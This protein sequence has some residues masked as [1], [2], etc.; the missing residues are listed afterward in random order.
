MV[1]RKNFVMLEVLA[2]AWKMNSGQ[3]LIVLQ[4]KQFLEV[5]DFKHNEILNSS[6]GYQI[7]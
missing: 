2:V 6:K 4:S 1:D 5:L 7:H 3:F